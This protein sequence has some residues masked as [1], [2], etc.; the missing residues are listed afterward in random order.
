MADETLR[1][2]L[3]K[4]TVGE[5]VSAYPAYSVSASGVPSGAAHDSGVVQSNG[6]LTFTDLVAGQRYVAIGTTS[7]LSFSTSP[8]EALGV[9]RAVID[10]NQ[11]GD[12]TIVAADS[13]QAIQVLGYTIIASGAVILRWKSGSNSVSGPMAVLANGGVSS[14][15]GETPM[16]QAE[17]GQALVLNLSAGVQVGGHIAYVLETE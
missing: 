17:V 12:T 11:S 15:N 5:T 6:S 14:W 16:L 13:S 7:S 2:V 10:T 4:F 1:N 8:S 3:S 9:R